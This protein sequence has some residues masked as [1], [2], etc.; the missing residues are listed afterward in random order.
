MANSVLSD[1]SLPSG[2]KPYDP[3]S[4]EPGLYQPTEH[5][6]GDPSY[7]GPLV[8]RIGGEWVDDG[9]VAPS[10]M[11][12]AIDGGMPDYSPAHPADFQNYWEPREPEQ[13]LEDIQDSIEGHVT[14]GFEDVVG[15]I[16]VGE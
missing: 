14:P 1:D 4:A 16:V 15:I 9:P 3:N 13:V 11:Q 12:Q 2:W 8:P 10:N 5:W 7:S 6:P